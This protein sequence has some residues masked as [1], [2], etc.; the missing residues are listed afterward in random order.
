MTALEEAFIE[1]H[2]ENPRVY[3]KIK[4]Y[5]AEAIARGYKRFSISVLVERVRWSEMIEEAAAIK[6]NNNHRAYYARLWMR[7]HPE[8]PN[9]FEIRK[10]S[11]N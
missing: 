1:F 2:G 6:I 8:H 9:F 3:E 4:R 5:A 10:T 7:D 11:C